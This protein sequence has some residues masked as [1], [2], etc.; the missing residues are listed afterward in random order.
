M[1]RHS[2]SNLLAACAV[3][4]LATMGTA[5][6][7][8]SRTWTDASGTFKIEAKFSSLENGKVKLILNDGRA[9]EIELGKL[10]AADRKYVEELNSDN[11]FK[12]AGENP[13]QETRPPVELKGSADPPP[14]MSVNWSGAESIALLGTDDEWQYEP[15]QVPQGPRPRTVSLPKKTDFFEK[16]EGMAVNLQARRAAL[17]YVLKRPGVGQQPATRLVMGDLQTGR[18]SGV[19]TVPGNLVPLAVHDD[20]RQVLM[21]RN[22]F[23]H[24]NADRLELWNVQGSRVAR[25][26]A[27]IPTTTAG[28]ERATSLGRSSSTTSGWRPQAGTEKSRSGTTWTPSRSATST[29]AATRS[30]PSAPTAGRSVSAPAN[31]SVCSTPG[32][33]R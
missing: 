26:L 32:P 1:N 12:P 4:A 19:V 21:R 16:L 5:Q 3:L 23:G 9:V 13:F 7:Q 24:G 2:L 28:E 30:P 25:A 20:G 15:G 11:P 14:V 31:G 22:D 18:V 17:G 29:S 33:C 6:A 8:E 27:W 10:S